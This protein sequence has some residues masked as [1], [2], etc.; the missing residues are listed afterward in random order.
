M[1]L[2]F[3]MNDKFDLEESPRRQSDHVGLCPHIPVYGKSAASSQQGIHGD[4][5]HLSISGET[6][7]TGNDLGTIICWL[8]GLRQRQKF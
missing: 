5:C 2:R 6:E 4:Q 3:V 8:S 7:D 1:R